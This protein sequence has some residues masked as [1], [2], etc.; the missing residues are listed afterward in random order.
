MHIAAF[1]SEVVFGPLLAFTDSI[2]LLS[3]KSGELRERERER[4]TGRRKKRGAVISCI[5]VDA[6]VGLIARDLPRKVVE[7]NLAKHIYA[8]SSV[9]SILQRSS[10]RS[11]RVSELAY[12]SFITKS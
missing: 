3:G 4:S 12:D 11:R 2:K 5:V 6:V 7:S 8:G 10:V 9:T 1:V